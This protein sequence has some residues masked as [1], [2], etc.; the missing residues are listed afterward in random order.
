MPLACA[1]DIGRFQ[2]AKND[3]RL[4]QMQVAQH[5]GK[6][7]ADGEH[8]FYRQMPLLRSLEIVF[9]RLTLDIL[10]HEVP[11]GRI[12]EMLVQAWQVRM[13]EMK[14]RSS[15]DCTCWSPR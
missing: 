14:V 11:V 2:V 8:L 10:H 4:A 6:L 9:K 1:H 5:F 13:R 7:Y 12:G 15:H 3:G